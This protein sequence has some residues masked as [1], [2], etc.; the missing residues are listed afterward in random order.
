MLIEESFIFECAK[1]LKTSSDDV[2]MHADGEQKTM[3]NHKRQ[4]FVAFAA[5]ATSHAVVSWADDRKV[6]FG[7]AKVTSVEQQSDHIN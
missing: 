3:T 4:S 1:T 7:I 5:A 2:Q 6:C